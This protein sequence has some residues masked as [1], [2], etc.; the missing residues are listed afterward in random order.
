VR[1]LPD[2]APHLPGEPIRL[3]A[4]P[5]VEVTAAQV[6]D[7]GAQVESTMAQTLE[8][9]LAHL[10]TDDARKVLKAACNI[11]DGVEVRDQQTLA[12]ARRTTDLGTVPRGVRVAGA[13][14]TPSVSRC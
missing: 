9:H 7:I 6:D 14:S 1:A 2:E 11:K 4:A 5:D 10:S 12:Q 3:P 13:A 8:P